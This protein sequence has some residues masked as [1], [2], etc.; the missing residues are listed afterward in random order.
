MYFTI[1]YAVLAENVGHQG[2]VTAHIDACLY[3]VAGDIL[4]DTTRSETDRV[5]FAVADTHGHD[6][7]GE[8][9]IGGRS[10]ESGFEVGH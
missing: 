9:S 4:R 7:S 10:G 6:A 8:G 5:V 1:P 3:E 2:G